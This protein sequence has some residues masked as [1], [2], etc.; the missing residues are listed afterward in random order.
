MKKFGLTPVVA[1][2]HFPSD[3]EEEIEYVQQRCTKL[4]LA[5]AV[6][7]GFAK[8][9]EGTKILAQ[10]VVDNINQN[11][12]NFKPLYS[13]NISTEAKIETIATEI[14]G[15]DGVEYS[16]TARAKLKIIKK[17]GYDTLPVCM[18]KTQKS[19]SDNETKIGRPTGFTINVRDF[20]FAA[21][22]GFIIPV[23]GDMMRMPAD[24]VVPGHGGP[25]L[26]WPQAAAPQSRYLGV[27]EEDT[28]AALQAGLTLGAAIRTIGRSEAGHWQLF[29]LHNPRNATVAYTELEWE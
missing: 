10:A 11:L 6:S 26:A 7:Y 20:E 21:G 4:G 16:S 12:N 29:D 18:A 2:N 13:W 14:Y 28:R 5:A 25:I 3:T 1:I 8:G 15:A 27:L 19:F 17:L 9:G 23:L 22:A 24:K